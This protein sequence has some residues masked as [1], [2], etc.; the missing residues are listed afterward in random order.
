MARSLSVCLIVLLSMLTWTETKWRVV[1]L[2]A[3]DCHCIT[4]LFFGCLLLQYPSF[5]GVCCC[6][7]YESMWMCDA[8]VPVWCQNEEEKVTSCIYTR[9]HA[10]LVVHSCI[11]TF[12]FSQKDTYA[13]SMYAY[14]LRIHTAR[15]SDK[16]EN[17]HTLDPFVSLWCSF[18][19]LFSLAH[20][21]R[22]RLG[23]LLL[24]EAP[25][26]FRL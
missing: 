22:N 21:F 25:G 19:R 8:R 9:E 26:R 14:I 3:I 18:C 1:S 23:P 15:P 5:F 13:S 11:Q 17:A 7:T 2:Y 4:A 12:T 24:K 16:Q 20:T 10:P 6:S